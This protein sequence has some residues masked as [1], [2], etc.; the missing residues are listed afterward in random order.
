MVIIPLVLLLGVLGWVFI[1]GAGVE[2]EPAAPIEV[3]NIERL[4]SFN[5]RI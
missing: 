2:Q 3:L 1:N 5:S 4:K